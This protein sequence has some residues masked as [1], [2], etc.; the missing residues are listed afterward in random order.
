MF[1]CFF[2]D[3][4]DFCWNECHRVVFNYAFFGGSQTVR[5]YLFVYKLYALNR[6]QFAEES[7]SFSEIGWY[8]YLRRMK[9]SNILFEQLPK[10]LSMTKAALADS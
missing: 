4:N 3:S 6:M 1:V 7:V 8:S 2:T 10:L 5:G 9:F